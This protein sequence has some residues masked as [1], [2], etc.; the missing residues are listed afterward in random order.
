MLMKAG[1]IIDVSQ[2]LVETIKKVLRSDLAEF[3]QLAKANDG[4]FLWMGLSEGKKVRLLGTI[5]AQ[6]DILE[7]AY[8][9]YLKGCS[10]C[11]EPSFPIDDGWRERIQSLPQMLDNPGQHIVK[12]YGEIIA[13]IWEGFLAAFGGW[14]Y[15]NDALNDYFQLLFATF[16]KM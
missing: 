2:D 12:P 16:V 7:W 3:E 5:Q 13:D 9:Q 15:S 10:A 4:E 14:R 11:G 6:V 8:Q 1:F